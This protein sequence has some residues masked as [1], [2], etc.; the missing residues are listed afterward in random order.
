MQPPGPDGAKTIDNEGSPAK[1]D[2]DKD[3]ELVA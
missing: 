1:K 2:E 3:P